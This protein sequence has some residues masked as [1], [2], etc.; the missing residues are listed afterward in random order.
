VARI[1]EFELVPLSRQSYDVDMYMEIDGTNISVENT[2]DLKNPYFR[3]VNVAVTNAPM[4]LLDS[5][6]QVS[7]FKC[8]LVNIT[9]RRQNN[10]GMVYPMNKQICRRA[11]LIP[12]PILILKTAIS[13]IT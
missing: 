10:I 5:D 12:M 3:S 2:L 1:V 11:M 13:I 9:S 7:Q 6:I 8:L 4:F